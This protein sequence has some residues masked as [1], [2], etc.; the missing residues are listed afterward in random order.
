MKCKTV[1]D[2]EKKEV[3]IY[4]DKITPFVR[5]IEEFVQQDS[6]EII[7]DD[8]GEIYKI[9][10]NDCCCFTVKEGR[11]YAIT[12]K[13]E[14]RIKQRLYELE[15]YLSDNF[16]KINQS[17]IVNAYKIEKFYAHISGTICVTLKNGYSDYV[18]RRQLQN[19]KR[20]LKI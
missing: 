9:A 16:V 19:V 7:G 3:V 5:Q 17:C 1:I 4:T 2:K 8:D 12:E 13:G 14:Y 11:V 15:N 6:T 18:S 20:R 10:V